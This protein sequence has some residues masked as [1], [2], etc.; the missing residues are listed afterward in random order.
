MITKCI[1]TSIQILEK[2]I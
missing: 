1:L 2:Q